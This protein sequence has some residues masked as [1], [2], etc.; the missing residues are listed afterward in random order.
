M[1]EYEYDSL[2][3]PGA[4]MATVNEWGGVDYV[5]MNKGVTPLFFMIP[6]QDYA[7]TERCGTPRFVNQEC[8]RISM[9]G[10]VF[11]QPVLPVDD[12]VKERFADAYRSW[13]AGLQQ[14]EIIGT[15]L[16]AWPLLNPV[17]VKE[18]QGMNILSI[19]DLA[20]V[21]DDNI[22]RLPGGREWRTKANAYLNHAKSLGKIEVLTEENG[23]LKAR[24]DALEKKMKQPRKVSKRRG[25]RP[26]KVAVPIEVVIA[27][28][29]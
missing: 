1:S 2:P 8:V 11:E 3:S 13:K 24:L 29:A 22:S 28:D 5:A 7:E 25:G 21:S 20:V 14:K 4:P 27:D 19:E 23:A 26:R 16:T 15:P 18:F 9:A 12:R 6:V 17:Q 10:N